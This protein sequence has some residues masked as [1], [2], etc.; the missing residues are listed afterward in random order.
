MYIYLVL[1]EMNDNEMAGHSMANH[2]CHLFFS[3]NFFFMLP[4]HKNCF[5]FSN[6]FSH[7]F[8]YLSSSF[9]PHVTFFFFLFFS[10]TG[11]LSISF[12]FLFPQALFFLLS[13]A[14]NSSQISPFLLH[15][16]HMQSL[17]IKSLNT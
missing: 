4:H 3:I 10:P 15:E 13:V 16:I 17:K 1:K 9:F 6:Y 11:G 14:E 7:P 2:S 5:I 8:F 12:I